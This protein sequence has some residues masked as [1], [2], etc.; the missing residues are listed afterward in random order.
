MK[1]KRFLFEQSAVRVADRIIGIIR[2]PSN[3]QILHVG[4]DPADKG[5]IALWAEVPEIALPTTQEIVRQFIVLRNED[6]I[7]TGFVF[8]TH[9]MAVPLLFVYEYTGVE[10]LIADAPKPINER[11][12]R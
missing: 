7:P 9:I 10:P 2:M 12:K 8:R 6:R 11:K 4:A 5:N 3:A 1:L